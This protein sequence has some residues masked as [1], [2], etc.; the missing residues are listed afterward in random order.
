MAIVPTQLAR[1]S[2]LLRTSVSQ[3]QITRTQKDL[4]KVQNELS[5]GKRI[6]APS[7]DPGDSAI[8]QQLQKSLEQ[9]DAYITNL[10]HA[11][12]A[13]SEADTTIGDLTSLLLEAKQIASA[14][15]GSDVTPDQ[16]TAAAA[17][18]GNL[19]NQALTLANRQ[20]EGSYL[21]GGDRATEPPF[22][23]VAGG[24][25][26][27]GTGDVLLN[28][29]DE[30]TS[31]SFN[32]S[33]IDVFGGFSSEVRGNK[34]LRPVIFANTRLRD[35]GGGA[36]NGVARGS[37]QINN[38]T[39]SKVVDLSGAD[40]VGNVIDAINAA[41]VGTI[42]ASIGA[43]GAGIDLTG[44][45]GENITITEVGGGTSAID[46]GI[47]MEN[48][49]GAGVPVGGRDVQARVTEFT[50]LTS[51]NS[52][53]GMSGVGMVITNGQTTAVVSIPGNGTMGDLINRINASGTGVIARINPAGTGL[54]VFNPIQG[55]TMS[56]GENGGT[57]AA[58]LGIRSMSPAT[59][60]TSLNNGK[61][62]RTVAGDDFQI[63]RSD[64]SSFNVDV[65]G[66]TVQD[67]INAINAA[68]GGAGVTASFATTGNGIVLTDTA[69]GGGTLA[70]TPLGASDAAA[71]LGLA[72]VAAVGNVITGTDANMPAVDGVFGSLASLRDALHTNSQSAI[73][74]AAGMIETDYD[75][76]V[77]VRGETGARVKEIESRQ[78]RLEDQNVATKS[79]LSSL[80]DTDFTE[81]VARF[82]TLQT[83]LQATLQTTG[84][85][86]NLSLLD[87][88][89]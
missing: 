6:N 56:I 44:G 75:R 15:V 53:V 60:L 58:D 33:G 39:V 86:L 47:L 27:N 68:D 64:G 61:G 59:Q 10:R 17:I 72:G 41:G 49:A 79:L 22:T 4:L 28:S 50:P 66:T 7:D 23:S 38:G 48:P 20:F 32:V 52:G 63:T 31:Q 11:Q 88:L 80:S 46:L 85:I 69:G 70:V 37:I 42:T 30:N 8:V 5:T 45:A 57:S 36:G 40:T 55:L 29:F 84:Q 24:V 71:D 3:G 9:R 12:S 16:R 82:Q 83:S 73:T 14:N 89:G 25:R 77:R 34:D 81:A 18:V 87:F 26:Y 78:G 1:V 76:V 35:L 54:D 13:L 2:N 74:A 67:L 21:F 43:V 51:L 65:A 19:Y 62:V